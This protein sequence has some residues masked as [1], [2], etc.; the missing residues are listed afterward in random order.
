MSSVASVVLRDP[1]GAVVA[2]LTLVFMSSGRYWEGSRVLE[3]G[4]GTALGSITASVMGAESVTA[5][6]RENTVLALAAK[7]MKSNIQDANK[8]RTAKISWGTDICAP[9]AEKYKREIGGCWDATSKAPPVGRGKGGNDVYDV[10]IGA[11]LTYT[12]GLVELLAKTLVDFSGPKTE[13]ILCWCE[14][15]LFTFNTDVM[16]EL[17]EKGI[18]LFENDFVVER[19]T[20][21]AAFDAG[22][23]NKNRS[24]ILRMKRK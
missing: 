19:I 16:T 10:I 9:D 3:L 8:F 14:P 22:L 13:V 4:C 1:A 15:T 11:D 7:N 2:R 23:S 18:P 5:S 21:G 20:Q 12:S 6:D 17:N 24:F